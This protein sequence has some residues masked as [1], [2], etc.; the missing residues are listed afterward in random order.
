MDARKVSE[1][2]VEG[3]RR[4]R[5]EWIRDGHDSAGGQVNLLLS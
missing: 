1:G 4:R 5:N 2:R 3:S